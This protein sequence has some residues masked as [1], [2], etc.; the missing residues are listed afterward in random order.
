MK[1]NLPIIKQQNHLVLKKTKSL[2]S[3]SNKL[4]N[5]GST[6]MNVDLSYRLY[7]SN[8]KMEIAV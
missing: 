3:L 1:K 4:L 2:L 8:K 6:L 7:I 5:T